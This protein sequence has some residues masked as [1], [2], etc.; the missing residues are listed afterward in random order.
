MVFRLVSGPV[1]GPGPARLGK[2]IGLALFL[3]LVVGLGV[4]AQDAEDGSTFVAVFGSTDYELNPLD[5]FTATEAQVYTAL[6]EGLVSYHPASLGPVPGVAESW[7]ILEDGTLY[8]FHL[9]ETA[10]YANG[11]RVEAEHF[12][13]TW[14]AMLD[15]DAER[16][17]SFMF[18][19]IAGALAYRRGEIDD[20]ADV[21]IRAVDR[22]TLEVRLSQPAG[23]F[24]RT[25][26]HHS[27]IVLHPDA[28]AG[29]FWA[30]PTEI[31]VNGPYRITSAEPG[32]IALVKNQQYWAAMEV[33]I[34]RVQLQ[35]TDDAEAATRAFNRGEVSWIADPIDFGNILFLDD[36]VRNPLFATSFYFFRVE[37][38]LADPLVRRALALLIDWD[39]VRSDEV[40]FAPSFRLVPEIPLYPDVEGI[41]DRDVE[42]ARA[43]LAEAGVEDTAALG[44]LVLR[45]PQGAESERILDVLRSSWTE[46]VGVTVELEQV[47]YPGYFDSL[48]EP[49]YALGFISWIGDYADPLTFLQ[50]FTADSN[51]NE[52]RYRNDEFEA[53]L[54][55]AVPLNGRER[56]ALMAEAET[57]LL[58]DAVVFPVSHSP[59]FNLI[60]LDRIAGW[61]ANPLDIHPF[62]WIR[63]DSLVPPPWVASGPLG[64]TPVRFDG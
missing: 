49:G 15:P 43:L 18:D 27:F 7:E 12:R 24:L 28:L 53:L 19:V 36:L 2:P 33:E 14:L 58:G 9:R 3:L 22:D 16:A 8:R 51:L 21:G 42:R 50:L 6:Y 20:P 11:D 46:S 32:R 48:E 63:F 62:R 5:S 31:P 40:Y 30:R 52:A 38:A 23:H 10:R 29:E 56:F 64:A 47:A 39:A 45:L 4:S 54:D 41:T 55:R 26:S 35:F 60:D 57:L 37:G 59:A 34:H 13:Q 25:L 17:Y 1:S 61:Y 44:P